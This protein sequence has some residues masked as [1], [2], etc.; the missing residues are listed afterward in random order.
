MNIKQ[1]KI[2]LIVVIALF[3]LKTKS[4]NTVI[5]DVPWYSDTVGMWGPSSTVWSINRVDTLVDFTVGPYAD[6]YSYVY[7]IPWPIDDSVGVIFDYGAYAS[8]QLIFEMTGWSGGAAKVNYPTKIKMDFPPNGSF[9]NGSW[10]TIPSEY[11]EQ[12][13]I[14]HPTDYDNWD[15]YADWPDAGK[16]ELYLNMDM[17]AHADLI[18][19]DPTDPFNISWDTMHVFDPIDIQLDTFDIFLVDLINGEYVIP[20]VAYHTDPYTGSTIIDS[21]YFLT[22]A[23]GWPLEFPTIFYDLIGISG[24]ISIPNIQNYTKWIENEQ[25]LYTWGNS[26]Y[27]HINLDIIKFIEVTCHYL[28][29]I[30]S[31]Q[32][33]E[34]VSQAMQYEEG[35]TSIYI[36]TDPISGDDFTA[37]LSWDLI[38]AEL[39]FT[40][41]MNQTL[42]FEDNQ[43]YTWFGIPILPNHYPN[44]WNIFEFPINV[45][46]NVLDTLGVVIESGT[47]DSIKF[48]AD[49]DLQLR[50]PC[51]D[52]D[53]LPVTI[54]HTIDP[55]LTNM[56]RDSVDVDFYIKVLDI[57]YSI[58]TQSNPIYSGSFL[59]YEDT[60]NLG[61]FAGPPLFGPPIFMPW[62]ID[63]FFIDTTFVP[64]VAIVPTNN[65]L[66]DTIIFDNILCYGTSTGSI[67]A[68]ALG[69]TPPYTYEWTDEVGIVISNN[70]TISNVSVGNYFVL[71]TD[72]NNCQVLDSATLINTNTQIVIT[73]NITN[74][75]CFGD[76][77]GTANLTVIGGT[78]PY[79]YTWSPNVGNTQNVSNLVAGTY[80]VSVTDN[81]GC[82]ETD[83]IEI[84]NL[85]TPIIITTQNIVDAT[86][87]NGNDGS[88]DIDV[89]GGMPSYY[90]NWSNG[91]NTQDISNL[92]SNNYILT[93]TDNN[94]CTETHEITVNQPLQLFI[95]ATASPEN[96]CPTFSSTLTVSG[97]LTYEWY[98]STGLSSTTGSTV[99]ATPTA[100][101]TYT[102]I[103]TDATGCT[104]TTQI[105]VT[106][107]ISPT[108]S[109]TGN[110][111]I[112]SGQTT[113]LT[114][115]GGVSYIWN[116]TETTDNIDVSPTTNTTYF[117][118]GTDANACTNTDE[119][120]VNV[121]QMPNANAGLDDEVC[122]LNYNLNATP[123]VGN[124]Y[125][126]VISGGNVNFSPSINNPDATIT[127]DYTNYYSLV[128]LEDNGNGCID[129]DTVNI[130]LTQIP[131]SNFTI[132]NI[133]CFGNTATINY[134]G[135]GNPGCTYIWNWGNANVTT[136]IG[137]GPHYANWNTD[138]IQTIGLIVSLNNCA[139]TE[140]F[141]NVL[142]PTALTSAITHTDILCFGGSNGNA[143]VEGLGGTPPYSFEWNTSSVNPSIS[144]L[145][146]GLYTVTITDANACTIVDST[147]VIEPNEFIIS[148][149]ENQNICFGQTAQINISGT[150]GTEPY[151]Y[152]W[153]G[154]PTNSNITVNTTITNTY[155]ATAVDANA[156]ASNLA[157][158]TIN[159][160][161]DI[162]M[163]LLQNTK[164]ICYGDSVLVTPTTTG[165]VEPFIFTNNNGDTIHNPIYIYPEQTNWYNISVID[166]CGNTYSSSVFV[167]VKPLPTINV[168]ANINSGC[169]PLTVNFNNNNAEV[170]QTHIWNFGDNTPLSAEK[171]PL[172]TYTKPGY[173]NIELITTSVNGCTNS[174]I[175]SNFISVWEQPVAN[176]TYTP[177]VPTYIDP[178]VNF[179]NTSTNGI[180]YNW[181]FGDGKNSNL[182]D[183]IHTYQSSGIYNVE[184][185]AISTK[186][187][188]DTI[189]YI[190]EI[191]EGYTFYAPTA[192][193]PDNDA[194]N[195]SFFVLGD[196]I[197][198]DDFLLIIYDRWGEIIWQTNKFDETG[199]Q[200]E[201]WNGTVNNNKIVQTG[202]YKWLAKFKDYNGA[203]HE[204]SGNIT[205]IK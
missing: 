40:N 17:Q 198:D 191:K 162:T 67:T 172:H 76:N 123:S 21:V 121:T 117:V 37:D 78:S 113:T 122:V 38:D 11:R 124:G 68:T 167:T 204:E 71:I 125:W 55:W 168:S 136:G 157:Y 33:L 61:S 193:S 154:V 116:T 197:I 150:G 178:T 126:S 87:F 13:T 1:L 140:T 107:Y 118:T 102:V 54:T 194:K 72:A 22:D 36:F 77:T 85:N 196:G 199:K 26:E 109:I 34:A 93:V 50:L 89:S 2:F 195:D 19:S 173:Y 183:P 189:T 69:G 137:M 169:V 105:T 110:T 112:C 106:V 57:S 115:N 59:L 129:S 104:A 97:A 4:Q 185:I 111:N 130:L 101:T 163:S 205:V 108:I 56:V 159:V 203:E 46:Y 180:P 120:T 3:A 16:I 187:C 43:E 161:T 96:V 10:E 184:L 70:S 23:T 146:A 100:T 65:P 94:N 32:G 30:P 90:Y 148:V 171:N 92:Y 149:T 114:G 52:Y 164:E 131:T 27:L 29:Y 47:T 91:A 202:V 95:N 192:F 79:Q 73:Q 86:C 175:Y 41:T 49:Y 142:N 181:D 143:A 190:V 176:F 42:S 20:W 15:I 7:Q 128:W 147:E 84:I 99:T 179:T 51:Y 8:M 80:I 103:G 64:D 166:A 66:H 139:Y 9:S 63:G 75:L 24:S 156:C 177:L 170:G 144:N 158:T 62:F 182:L 48:C 25:R 6:Q 145:Y 88:V 12:D 74:V 160:S 83:T 127:V 200:S 174:N 153:N 14:V 28:S 132:S 135:T 44:V 186:G 119:H 5:H 201:K 133:P 165:G 35:D 141:V 53:T 98:P 152:Y 60:I 45:D 31:M 39:L 151:T 134:T 58:G 155:L 81:V 138:G 188:K 18:Y 82:I